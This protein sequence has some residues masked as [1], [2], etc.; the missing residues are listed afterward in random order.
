ML[1]SY[2]ATLAHA[3]PGV[4]IAVEDWEL[5]VL[6]L[7]LFGAGHE[8][9]M[10]AP[11]TVAN[12]KQATIMRTVAT[13]LTAALF[14]SISIIDSLHSQGLL[15]EEPLLPKSLVNESSMHRE[16]QWVF[17]VTDSDPSSGYC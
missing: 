5:S 6:E 3:I 13:V 11:P 1:S 10:Y 15:H 17:P 14:S 12:T 4:V 2:E 7:L 9:R 16:L 8:K